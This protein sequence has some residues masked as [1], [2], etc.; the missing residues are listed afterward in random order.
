VS[1][2]PDPIDLHVAARLRMRRMMQGVSQ[3]ALAARIGVTF[4]QIQKYEKGQ[5]RI[6]ASRLFQLAQALSAPIGYFFEGLPDDGAEA[7]VI[8]PDVIQSLTS[9]E[10]M[11]LH[12]AFQ[13]LRGSQTRRKVVEL[14]TAMAEDQAPA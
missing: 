12:M 14:L 2:T 9:P 11:Q 10:G 3:E 5:N 6:G 4:Q 13:K 8:E 7:P 1:R